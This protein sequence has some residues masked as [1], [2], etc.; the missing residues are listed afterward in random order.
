MGT[1]NG[2]DVDAAS[3]ANTFK[4]LGYKVKIL[5]DQTVAQMKKLLLDGKE[6][7]KLTSVFTKTSPSCYSLCV[8]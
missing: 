6:T 5:N 3:V 7:L 1:R 4:K 2:T 8:S